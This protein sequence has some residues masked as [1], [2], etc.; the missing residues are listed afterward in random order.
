MHSYRKLEELY[1]LYEKPMYHIAMAI[2][3]NHH[4]AEDAV[5]DAFGRLISSLDKLDKPES[6]QTKAYII[7]VIRST[8]INIY[9]KNSR[10]ADSLDEFEEFT[11]DSRSD[12]PFSALENKELANKILSDMDE[13]DARIVVLRGRDELPYKEIAGI[14]SMNEGTVRKRFERAKKS[15]Q[16]KFEGER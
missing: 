3:K 14:M 7:K 11:A 10:C 5:S 4:Q 6:V 2:L 16:L 9:R 1:R 12:A 15:V 13:E 8:A